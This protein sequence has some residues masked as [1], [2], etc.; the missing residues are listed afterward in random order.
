[1]DFVGYME[2]M[3]QDT[4]RS[5]EKLGP[6]EGFG[7]YGFGNNGTESIFQSSRSVHHMTSSGA[8]DAWSRLANNYTTSI[9]SVDP[10]PAR[11]QY[12]IRRIE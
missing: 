8:S 3:E 1:M 4:S 11:S 10:T 5:L 9:K 7:A 2:S 6:W 12:Y